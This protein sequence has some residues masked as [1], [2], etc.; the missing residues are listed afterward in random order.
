MDI[1]RKDA[2]NQELVY[3]PYGNDDFE[4]VAQEIELGQDV[5][6]WPA[7]ILQEFASEHPYAFQTT[8]PE[9]EFERIDE[10]SGTAF[11]A[12][13]L[14][15]PY[16]TQGL[17]G[18]GERL[19]QEPEKVAVPVI[20][21]S[22]HLKPFHVFIRGEKIM[23]LTE[24]RFA[25]A[26]SGSSIAN[27]LD[28]SFQPSP[29]F[30]DKMMPPT[31]GYLGNLYG[32]SMNSGDGGYG[33]QDP[34]KGASEKFEPKLEKRS[35]SAD[36][37]KERTFIS[38]LRGTIRNQD[39]DQ[40]QKSMGDERIV[41]GFAVNKTL[42]IVREILGTRPTSFDDYTDFVEGA[43][44]IHLVCMCRRTNGMWS[45]TET[46]D[47]FFKPVVKEMKA[48]DVVAKYSKIRP[49]IA[50]LMQGSDQILIES[51][52][53][54]HVKPIIL[55]DH[56]VVAEQAS[57]DGHYLLI[58]NGGGFVEAQIFANVMDYSGN[59]TGLKLAVT[60]NAYSLQEAIVGQ[61][62]GDVL[63][64]MAPGSVEVGVEGTFVGSQDGVQSAII[65]FRVTSVGFVGSYMVAQA[66]GMSGEYLSFVFMPGVTRFFN[67]TGITDPALG[68]LVGGNVYYVPPSFHFIAL[69]KK[70]K[71]VD[72]PRDAKRLLSRK[73][74]TPERGMEPFS[75]ETSKRGLSRALRIISSGDGSITLKGG[76]LSTIGRDEELQDLTG[77]EAHWILSLLGVSLD[78]A[79]K[80]TAM[81]IGRGEVNVSNLRPAKDIIKRDLIQDRALSELA[82]VF[83]RNLVK[84]ASTLGD[85]RSADAMLSLNFVNES[86]LTQFMENVP[87]FREIEEKLAEL[88]LYACLGLKSQ[89]PEQAVLMA[90]QSLNE[91]NEHLEYLSSMM[92]MPA[93][94]SEPMPAA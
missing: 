89:V 21:E 5:R 93:S 75:V 79:A 65:P 31:V 84:A 69:G 42:N 43:A 22:F 44:P 85:P 38:Q 55:E 4:K 13:I 62:M 6:E 3:R 25:E 32:N 41:S 20:I 28:P 73:I 10:K 94:Q 82:S 72:D 15:K 60:G 88:Y 19:E 86:N 46:S 70:L 37:S 81:A 29:T 59:P 66:V 51:D 36:P 68:S 58:T 14:R 9:I 71:L 18:A 39:Y 17:G 27:G 52:A 63:P 11:G 48:R 47:Y 74:F 91:V 61:K 50:R 77:H 64:A 12:I 49:E 45:V 35:G 57:E 34:S 78:E 80:I 40:F 76:I 23:P 16:Q 24:A 8:A 90:M 1:A 87:A 7:T 33:V 30:S 83:R 67:A 53:R 56:E 26:S 54:A 92:R 2:L